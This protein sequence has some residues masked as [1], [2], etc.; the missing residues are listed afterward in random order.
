LWIWVSLAIGLAVMLVAVSPVAFRYF[1]PPPA[2]GQHAFNPPPSIDSEQLE[3]FQRQVENRTLT[4]LARNLSIAAVIA[5]VVGV[6]LARWLVA[7]LRRLEEGAQAVARGQLDVRLPVVGS[8]EM[9]SVSESFNQMTSE[10]Q[11]QE[12]LRRNLLA[13]VTHELRHPVH[14][15]QGGLR[16]ILDGV[17]TLSMDEID[18]LLEQTQQLSRLVDDLHELALAE[19]QE[20]S[21]HFQRT[22]LVKLAAHTSEA[23]Q[24]LTAD[25]GIR[26]QV[27]APEQPLFAM[28]DPDRLRQALQN[29]LGNALRYTPSGGSIAISLGYSDDENV[30]ITVQDTGSGIAAEHLAHIFDRFYRPD[31]SRNRQI[32]GAG[33]GLSIAQAIIQAHGGQIRAESP[34]LGLGSAFTITLPVEK[35]GERGIKKSGMI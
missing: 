3:T 28:V 9:R 1:F 23:F 29:L 20:L 17:Y 22:D 12:Q 27:D 5:L 11:R 15:L 13:D 14:V 25:Q 19:A 35:T 18:R 10:L 26:L 24:A 2:M 8:R 31:T 21:M 30:R 4:L 16:A 32:S 6:L 34:G 33:L 7:P